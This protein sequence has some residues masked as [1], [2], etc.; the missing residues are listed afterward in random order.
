MGFA[1]FEII[2]WYHQSFFKLF[3][4]IGHD[5]LL[6]LR[7]TLI[8]VLFLLICHK[9]FDEFFPS[10]RRLKASFSELFNGLNSYQIGLIA[11]ASSVG[12]EILFR[13]AIQPLLG[14][15]FTSLLFALMHVDPEG[16]SWGWTVWA[17]LGG[18]VMGGAA[19]A[20]GSLW[21]PIMIHFGVNVI[22]ISRI[23]RIAPSKSPSEF[24]H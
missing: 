4:V 5:W 24:V 6:D 12:E 10:Y 13:G 18:L 20:T 22:S 16:K 19:L 1:G 15:W 23:S 7:I 9:C 11:F 14:V 17:F 8:S 21:A 3:K 2:W